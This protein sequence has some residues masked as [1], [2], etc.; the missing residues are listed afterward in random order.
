M[1]LLIVESAGSKADVVSDETTVV[2]V[3]DVDVMVPEFVDL[4]SPMTEL[5]SFRIE[6][7][8]SELG[9]AFS[10]IEDSSMLTD[11]VKE[12]VAALEVEEYELE[13]EEKEGDEEEEGEFTVVVEE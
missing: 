11:S 9:L 10:M 8:T 3:E 12:R 4:V 1:S 13:E 7:R 6:V 2:L 5:V